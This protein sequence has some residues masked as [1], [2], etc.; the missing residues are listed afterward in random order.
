MPKQ[1][2][3]YK[4]QRLISISPEIIFNSQQ[5]PINSTLYITK[6]GFF[7][8]VK[9]HYNNKEN[10]VDYYIIL[11]C[12]SGQ[13]WCM[14]GERTF[15][16]KENQCIILPPNKPYS[17]GTNTTNPWTILDSFQRNISLLFF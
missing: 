14:I 8:A 5:N 9:Y 4:S 16:V 7:H 3:G 11:Y 10:G 6:I 15:E 17:S 2:Q 1:K 13:G 12:T